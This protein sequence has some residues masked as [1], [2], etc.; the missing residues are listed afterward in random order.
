MTQ[1]AP[2]LDYAEQSAAAGRHLMPDLVRAFAILGIVLVNVAYF[3]YPGDVTYH[4]GGLNTGLDKAAYFGVNAFFL[5]KSYTLFSFMFGVGVAYQIVS[6]QKRGAG[7]GPRYTRRLLG[8]LILGILHVTFAF[9]GDIL[10][11]Y[12]IFGAVL[13]LFRNLSVKALKR[14]A[15]GFMALQFIL[16]ILATAA[17]Y[18]WQAFD[19]AD[20]AKENAAMLDGVGIYYDVFGSGSFAQTIALR[21][22]DWTELLIYAGALQGPFVMAFFIWGLIAV[23]TGVLTDMKAKV[24]SKARRVY[25]PMGIAL[26]L[27]GAYIYMTSNLPLS[28]PSFLG[29]CFIIIGAPC[30][31]LGYLGLIAKW[32]AAPNS[33]LKTFMSRG[34]TATLSAY[35]LQSII[36]SLIFN[37]YG[38]G[39]YGQLGAF[40]CITIA[41][42]VGIFS[43]CF[44]SLWRTKFQYGPFEFLLRR[45]TYWGDKR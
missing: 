21:W 26:N 31:T 29:L 4:G 33:A 41:L 20:M 30:L 36:L 10:I 2:H 6:A 14:W 18:A 34:G 45:F 32:V 37:G 5:F 1:S 22:S 23:K 11:Y 12:A 17:M 39:Q 8:L 3:A 28:G 27:T 42:S 38:F 44:V 7:F 25:L 13:Y 35:L 40:A 16:I 19:P 24:W 15:I 43:L 9:M